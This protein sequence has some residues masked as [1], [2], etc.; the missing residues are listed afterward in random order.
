MISKILVGALLLI[1][2]AILWLWALGAALFALG[3]PALMRSEFGFFRI[4]NGPAFSNVVATGKATAD[5]R[6]FIGRTIDRI[7]LQLGGTTFTKAMITNVRLLANERVIFEDTG[8]RI[9]TRNQYR[10]L[11]A[12]AAF[13]PLDFSEIRAHSNLDK[14]AG[15]IDT[16]GA[17]IASLTAEVDISGATAPTLSCQVQYR[18]SPAVLPAESVYNR[19]IAKSINKSFSFAGSGTFPMT[20][21]LARHPDSFVKRIHLFG[22]IVTA[23]K[24]RKTYLAGNVL[25]EFIDVTD[26]QNDFYQGEYQR[27]PQASHVCIDF[28]PD[29]DVRAALP[30]GDAAAMEYLLTVSGAGVV[31]AVTELLDPLSNN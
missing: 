6:A 30:L 18:R 13:L 25:E 20:L 15:A 3:A 16:L 28:I 14:Y 23:V 21:A 1:F 19:L 24:V 2:S 5:F 4:I 17:G 9:D 22:T 29:C 8:S 7:V 10:G 31:T 27:T 11:A 12:N 26:A